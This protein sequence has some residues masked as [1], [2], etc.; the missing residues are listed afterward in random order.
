MI[1]LSLKNPQIVG[2]IASLKALPPVESLP[3]AAFDVAE[4]RLLEEDAADDRWTAFPRAFEGHGKPTLLT[5]RTKE[6]GGTWDDAVRTPVFRNAVPHVSA[7]DIEL[8][9]A[10]RREVIAMA[11]DQGR[12]VIGSFHDFAGTPSLEQLHRLA[13]QACAEKLDVLK[14]AIMVGS[15]EDLWTLIPFLQESRKKLPV[16][17]IGMGPHGL[18]SRVFFPMIGS[19]LTYGFLGDSTAPGQIS[20]V[21]MRELMRELG[22]G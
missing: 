9:S 14:V 20:C 4:I 2:A 12:T 22:G 19:C 16:C 21:R 13:D 15:R 5:V 7:V 6:E 1:P 8:R 11:K 17:I 18:A 3:L 10:I